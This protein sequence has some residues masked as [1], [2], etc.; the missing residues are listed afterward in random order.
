MPLT[1]TQIVLNQT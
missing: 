1:I